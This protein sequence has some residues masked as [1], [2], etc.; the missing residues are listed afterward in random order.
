[1][2]EGPVNP[3][4]DNT[5]FG[6]PGNLSPSSPYQG[7]NNPLGAGPNQGAENWSQGSWD[8]DRVRRY[9][10]SRGITPNASSPDYWAARWQEWGQRDPAYFLQRLAAADEIIGGPQNSPWATGSGGGNLGVSPTSAFTNQIRQMLTDRLKQLQQGVSANDPLI[11]QSVDAARLEGDRATALSN[12]ML[13]ERLWAGGQGSV[14][15]N[16][17]Q[18]GAQQSAE[19]QAAGLGT[20]RANLTQRLY[21]QT[22]S[23]FQNLIQQALASGDAET[24]RQI[25][26]ALADLEAQIQ[27]EQLGFNMAQWAQSQNNG[28]VNAGMN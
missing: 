21:E 26:M 9:F 16:A 22:R 2:G 7:P 3:S 24:A 8:A 25:Q 12:K 20:L 13:A 14:D 17:V 28:A 15:T 18:Q 10:A 5:T 6:G 4:V 19:R 11:N 23:E 1:M 27:R